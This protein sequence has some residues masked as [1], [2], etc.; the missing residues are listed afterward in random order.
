MSRRRLKAYV[1]AEALISAAV[2]SLAGTLAVTLLIWSAQS[3]DRSQTSIGAMKA[4]DRLYEE[5]RLLSPSA[6]GRPA[7]GVL[8]RFQW[9]RI[10]SASLAVG[11]DDPKLAYAPTPLRL[12]VRWTSGGRVEQRQ[13]T[14]IVRPLQTAPPQP[15]SGQP[16]PAP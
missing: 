12:V 5:S 7:S 15:A 10:P 8:G 6:L 11:A 1:L 3:I 2:A 9:L 14:A 13:L 4:L 16:E